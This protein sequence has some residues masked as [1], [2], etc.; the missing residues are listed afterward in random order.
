MWQNFLN[1]KLQHLGIKASANMRVELSNLTTTGTV[2]F[3]IEGDNDT[4][5]AISASVVPSDLTNLVTALNDQSSR[6]GITA[7]LSSNKKR[8][9]MEKADG[10]DIFLSDYASS[11]PR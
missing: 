2:E 5:I 4:P 10:K 8:I 6:T 9:I 1:D 7:I 3:K 11:A